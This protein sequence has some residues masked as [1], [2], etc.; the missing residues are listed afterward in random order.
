MYGAIVWLSTFRFFVVMQLSDIHIW[1]F[2]QRLTQHVAFWS[3]VPSH[4]PAIGPEFG[5]A[6][7][8]DAGAGRDRFA[9]WAGC[10]VTRGAQGQRQ[11]RATVGVAVGA[12]R[13][14]VGEG[15]ETTALDWGFE[16]ILV[17]R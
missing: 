1:V 9:A 6:H 14:A 2:H 12:V 8:A 7:V 15:D 4:R 5:Q 17:F 13:G 16:I 3:L 10:A 11:R